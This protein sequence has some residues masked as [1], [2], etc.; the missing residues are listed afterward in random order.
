MTDVKLLDTDG[1]ESVVI[2][3]DGAWRQMYNKNK[4]KPE[5]FDLLVKNEYDGVKEFLIGQN[6][7]DDYSFISLDMR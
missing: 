2:C 5:V 7:F 6:C 4:L 1:I 3:S